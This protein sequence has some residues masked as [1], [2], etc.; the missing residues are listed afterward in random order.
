MSTYRAQPAEAYEMRPTRQTRTSMH[1]LSWIFE[2]HCNADY[3]LRVGKD[4]MRTSAPLLV[5]AVVCTSVLDL[6]NTSHSMRST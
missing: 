6:T 5:I 3:A 4:D 1:M 2:C